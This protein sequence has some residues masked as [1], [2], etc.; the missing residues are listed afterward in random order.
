MA[1]TGPSADNAGNI[2]LL[3]A[4]GDFDTTLNAS[5]FPQ[6]RQLWQCV[7]QAFHFGRALRRGLF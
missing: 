1:D 2:Y 6:Q 7:S 3:D 5:G 4:N